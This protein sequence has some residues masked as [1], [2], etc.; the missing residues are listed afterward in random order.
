MGEKSQQNSWDAHDVHP[1]PAPRDDGKGF[2]PQTSD[3]LIA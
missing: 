3:V 2:N 1:V